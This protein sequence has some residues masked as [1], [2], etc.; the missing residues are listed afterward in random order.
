[1][2]LAT[3]LHLACVVCGREYPATDARYV[4]DDHGNEGI[5]DVIYDYD[6]VD[7]TRESLAGIWQGERYSDYRRRFAAGDVKGMICA[8]CRKQSKKS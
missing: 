7:L 6:R 3:V 4:C 8:C 5:L 1:M 2:S